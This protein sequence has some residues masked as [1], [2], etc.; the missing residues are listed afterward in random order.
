MITGALL[1][2]FYLPVHFLVGGKVSEGF[3]NPVSQFVAIATGP[4]LLPVTLLAARR[5]AAHQIG[6][7]GP[8]PR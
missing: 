4:L 5:P 8:D 1:I 7:S 3:K 2:L 6:L